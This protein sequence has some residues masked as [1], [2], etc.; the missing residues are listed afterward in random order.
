MARVVLDYQ[1]A[2]LEEAA[3]SC[4]VNAFRKSSKGEFVI[5][6]SECID[7]GVCQSIVAD[8]IID[9]EANAEEA[10]IKYNADNSEVW[11]KV[12]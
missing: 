2:D 8:S 10:V 3:F 7:C 5:N 9:E 6:P 4:P 11:D 12:Q 1:A